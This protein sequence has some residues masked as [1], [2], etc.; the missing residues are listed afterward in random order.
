MDRRHQGGRRG[1]RELETLGGV[2]CLVEKGQNNGQLKRSLCIPA[3][4]PSSG[5]ALKASGE[6]W[7]V[8]C[9]TGRGEGGRMMV[10]SDRERNGDQCDDCQ[11][12]LVVLG[13]KSI[14]T[15]H[16]QISRLPRADL[17]SSRTQQ[18]HF[19]A[20]QRHLYHA[21]PLNGSRQDSR[22]NEIFHNGSSRH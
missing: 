5:E 14:I 13:Q 3:K 11:L 21:P 9:V 15:L 8:R 12:K 16:L 1:A 19:S 18:Y 2:P 7:S 20:H 17:D 22:P 4:D 6:V 10:V